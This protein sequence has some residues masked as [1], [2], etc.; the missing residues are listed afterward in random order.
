MTGRAALA[1]AAC[2]ALS[3]CNPHSPAWLALDLAI[4][5]AP[6]SLHGERGGKPADDPKPDPGAEP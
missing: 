2:L 6:D 1:L 4:I 3:G 5:L